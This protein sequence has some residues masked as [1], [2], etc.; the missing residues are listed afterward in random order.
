MIKIVLIQCYGVMQPPNA[1]PLSIEMLAGI[2]NQKFG[3][4]ITIKLLLLD[5]REDPDGER[6]SS[7]LS[8]QK[9]ITIVGVAIPQSTYFLAL[10]F[11][12]HLRETHIS[13]L[14]VLGHAIPTHSPES[15][16]KYFPESLIVRGWGETAICEIV[17][18]YLTGQPD[19]YKVHSIVFQANNQ[20]VT[21]PIIWPR[22]LVSPRRIESK[23]FFARVESSRGCHYDVCTFCTRQPKNPK[24][25]S[26][27]RFHTDIVLS[28]IAHLKAKGIT[29]FTF[30]DEDFIGNDL[31]G[32]E[33]IARGIKDI[34]GMQFSLSLR[35][36]NVYN[37][38]ETDEMN[39]RRINLFQLLKEAGLSLVYLGVES[40]SDTQLK[41][42]GKGVRAID[43]IK[44][45]EVIEAI[46]IPMELGYILFDPL[47]TFSELQENVAWLTSRSF[48]KYVG[49]LFNNLRVQ[50]D[51]AFVS[52]LRFRGLLGNYNPDTIEYT[53]EY[54]DLFIAD[55]AA[56]CLK[57]KEEIDEI[58]SH[59]RNIQRTEF[60][61]SYCDKF[62]HEMRLLDLNVLNYLIGSYKKCKVVKLDT[63][64]EKS[65]LDLVKCLKQGLLSLHFISPSIKTLIA[66]I[67]D[68]LKEDESNMVID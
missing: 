27:F 15:F 50:R 5:A 53:Y 40:L 36:D 57:W 25:L 52:L 61:N 10:N 65:R 7:Q 39:R 41:R 9:D 49:Q 66:A 51:S 26:W 16:L 12:K 46:E 37:P 24:T 31:Q 3:D 21:T 17:E 44:A 55:I 62:V 43:S 58:Y 8:T 22:I 38:H 32:A 68:F 6:L 13:P 23:H 56:I 11:L 29:K 2:L 14:I 35:V 60:T 33:T 19:W 4:L 28:E 63:T 67:N 20:I 59:A 42:Y 64:F 34:G 30:A 54:Q 1:E 48:P 45:V 47:L 18:Q